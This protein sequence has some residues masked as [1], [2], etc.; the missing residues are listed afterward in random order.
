MADVHLANTPRHVARRP[1]YFNTMF[2]ATLVHGIHIVDPDRHPHALIADFAPVAE[3]RCVRTLAAPA[4][5]A[6]A[7]EDFAVVCAHRS[8]RRRSAQLESFPPA[9]LLK[10]LEALPD[11]G[12][13]Q[14]R[15]EVLRVHIGV[16]IIRT[17]Q[18]VRLKYEAS[19]SEYNGVSG[20][21]YPI[22]DDCKHGI[23]NCR[24]GATR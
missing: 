16:L 9:E 6:L 17:G 11:I 3:R 14:N 21:S 5:R 10:P 4:L 22:Q 8:K 18:A 12:D 20:A 13:I 19:R 2:Q 23:S 15:R 1:G 7:Q 24:Y